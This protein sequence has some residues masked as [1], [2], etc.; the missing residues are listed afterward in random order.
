M[1]CSLTTLNGRS[2]LNKRGRH[3]ALHHS[4]FSQEHDTSSKELDIKSKLPKIDH[5][6]FAKVVYSAKDSKEDMAAA[7]Y[8]G[9]PRARPPRANCSM[10]TTGDIR[11]SRDELIN[12]AAVC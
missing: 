12:R 9:D 3:Q 4:T 10:T 5:H 11:P 7:R 2:E 1:D 6:S 8:P